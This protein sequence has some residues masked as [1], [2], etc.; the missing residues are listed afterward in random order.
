MKSLCGR[1]GI[2]DL[3]AAEDQYP[4]AAKA[5]GSARVAAILSLST[6]VGMLCPGLHSLFSGFTLELIA[7]DQREAGLGF[8]VAKWHEK[9][10]IVRL[11][12]S[13]AGI[14]GSVLAFERFPPVAQASLSEVTQYA[15]PNEFAG[16]TA[17]VIGGSRGLGEITAKVIAA[18]GGNTIITYLNGEQDAIFLAEEIRCGAP[19]SHCQIL[20]LDVRG[21]LAG[22]LSAVAASV[23][24]L[25]YFAT[26]PIFHPK[27]KGFVP[28]LFEE[29]SEVYV[30]AFHRCCQC[31]ASLARE[32]V[33][34]FYPSSVFIDEGAVEMIEYRIAKMAGEMLCDSMNQSMANIHVISSR[35]P[36][37]LTDQTA[38]VIPVRSANPFEVMLPIIRRVQT[39]THS[40]QPLGPAADRDLASI[41]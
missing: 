10:R 33:V 6:I 7:E 38:T 18:G 23:T 31:V 13:G 4:H 41:S 36:R 39:R 28:R 29:F 16:S 19:R 35:L 15:A 30:K 25:Y 5:I 9:R 20:R 34:A 11:S 3:G 24:H 26:P 27:G 22:Q 32:P 1:I 40:P 21:D 37:M 8:R 14:C 12:I 2:A 17:L